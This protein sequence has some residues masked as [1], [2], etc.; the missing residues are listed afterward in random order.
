MRSISGFCRNCPKSVAE[1]VIARSHSVVSI[2][3]LELAC[4]FASY[5]RIRGVILV[6]LQKPGPLLEIL[7][8]R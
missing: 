4:L 8:P 5:Q 2:L 3:K 1:T 6:L 7:P